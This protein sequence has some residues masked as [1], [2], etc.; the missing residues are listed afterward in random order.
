MVT[1]NCHPHIENS[2][3]KEGMVN[4]DSN[5][6]FQSL[7]CIHESGTKSKELAAAL[8]NS[9]GCM[10]GGLGVILQKIWNRVHHPQAE[11]NNN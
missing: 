7:S 11:P 10:W 4:G 8:Q 9:N 3:L 2:F 5:V 1:F 6:Q